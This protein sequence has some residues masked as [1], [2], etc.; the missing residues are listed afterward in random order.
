MFYVKMIHEDRMTKPKQ[1]SL[2]GEIILSLFQNDLTNQFS[3]VENPIKAEYFELTRQSSLCR[4][5]YARILWRLIDKRN[6]ASALLH[7]AFIAHQLSS[8][9]FFLVVQLKDE[10]NEKER[11]YR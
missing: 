9:Y 3:E 7:I 11:P 10:I 8:Q 5:R 6:Q 1:V 4:S 2:K